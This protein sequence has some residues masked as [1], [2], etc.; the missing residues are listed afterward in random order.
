MKAVWFLI[1]VFVLL[2]ATAISLGLV[3][4]YAGGLTSLW[5]GIGCFFAVFIALGCAE[6][7][8]KDLNNLK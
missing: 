6:E 3:A 1:F 2:V 5:C 7:I 8:H 4:Y